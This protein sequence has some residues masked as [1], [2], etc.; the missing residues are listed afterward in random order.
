MKVVSI[1]A[2]YNL[3]TGILIPDSVLYCIFLNFKIL[4]IVCADHFS[5]SSQRN[6]GV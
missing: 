6:E 4:G 3:N 2:G 1:K 5:T